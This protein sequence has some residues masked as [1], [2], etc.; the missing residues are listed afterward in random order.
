MGKAYSRLRRSE[1]A[2]SLGDSLCVNP[3]QA[4]MC[5]TVIAHEV[6]A[7]MTT[8][9]NSVV[10]SLDMLSDLANPVGMPNT[11]DRETLDFDYIMTRYLETP[12][13]YERVALGIERGS[14]WTSLVGEEA[15]GWLWVIGT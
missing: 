15:E 8:A 4:S 7:D 11:Q 12:E 10:S 5:L 1:E 2:S 3:R 14:L 13:E 9:L 6:L